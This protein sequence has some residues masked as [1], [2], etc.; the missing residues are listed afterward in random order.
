MQIIV[1]F[2]GYIFILFGV[3]KT[4]NTCKQRRQ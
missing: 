4:A 3:K 1:K 2:S